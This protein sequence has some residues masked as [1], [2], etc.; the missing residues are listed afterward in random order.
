M[1]GTLLLRLRLVLGSQGL[2]FWSASTVGYQGCLPVINTLRS[3][4]GMAM[5]LARYRRI[6]VG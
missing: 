6:T 4:Y 5:D 1:K 3:E 2:Q